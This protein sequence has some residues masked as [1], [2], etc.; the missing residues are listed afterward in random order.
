MA[1]AAPAL[2]TTLTFGTA[3]D[4]SLLPPRPVWLARLDMDVRLK[5][6]EISPVPC[7]T[8]IPE[9]A[10]GCSPTGLAADLHGSRVFVAVYGYDG[11]GAAGSPGNLIGGVIAFNTVSNTIVGGIAT[12]PYPPQA[13]TADPLRPRLLVRSGGSGELLSL[14]DT[15]SLTTVAVSSLAAQL[16]FVDIVLSDPASERIYAVGG[17][18]APNFVPTLAVVDGTT[19]QIV[20]TVSLSPFF[21]SAPPPPRSGLFTALLVSAD[22]AKVYVGQGRRLA[23]IAVAT[24]A[25]VATGLLECATDSVGRTLRLDPTRNVL[26]APQGGLGPDIPECRGNRDPAMVVLD[27]GTLKETSAFALQGAVSDL[28]IRAGDGALLIEGDWDGTNSPLLAVDPTSGQVLASTDDSGHGMLPGLGG[29]QLFRFQ[30]GPFVSGGPYASRSEQIRV[31]DATSLNIVG[32]VVLDTRP[33]TDPSFQMNSIKVVRAVSIPNV[34]LAVEYFYAA[35]G[36]YFTTS[37]PLEIAA[38][39][40]GR[41]PGWQRTGEVMPVYAQRDDAPDGVVPVCRFYGRPEKGLDSHFYSASTVECAQ[42]QQR[43]SDAW[44]LEGSEVFDVYP[45]DQVTGACLFQTTPVYRVYNNRADANHRYTTS[46][47]IRSSMLQQGWLPEGYGPDSVA[48]CVPR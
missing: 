20:S 39:D 37:S 34:S 2:V 40:N 31:L 28:A 26:Y 46:P 41:F 19:L 30:P 8:W 43:F 9:I 16:D 7:A 18:H 5:T 10:F 27:A 13:V 23:S 6:A 17:G 12:G 21:D 38:L 25:F 42:V 14:I 36:H 4:G 35:V 1:I 15:K 11:K 24:G 29:G 22:G 44:L 45:A 48:F 3:F 33:A 32:S 47:E